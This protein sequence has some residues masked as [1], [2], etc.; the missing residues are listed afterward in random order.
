[1]G[2]TTPI[3]EASI[4]NYAN[5]A[6]TKDYL[7]RVCPECLAKPEWKGGYQCTCGFSAGHWS[8]LKEVLKGTTQELKRVVLRQKGEDIV[9]KIHRMSRES[10]RE[11]GDAT[12]QEYGVIVKDSTSARN[13]KKLLIAVQRLAQVIVL[14]W[15]EEY[16]QKVALLTVSESN[17][18]IIREIM[19]LNLSQIEETV[20]VSLSEVTEQEINEAEQ[21][22]KALPEATEETLKVKDWRTETI[23]VAV[24]AEKAKVQDLEKIL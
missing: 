10:F 19:P 13:I 20:R 18:I 24:T 15:N 1:M 3:G 2:F 4:T 23:H 14:T 12:L 5:M 16:E 11:F 6:E 22:V 7:D 9:A 17:R 21:F 8:K